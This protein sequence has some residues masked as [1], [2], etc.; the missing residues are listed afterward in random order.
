[1]NRSTQA[2]NH[3][4][5]LGLRKLAHQER[6]IELLFEGHRYWDLKRWKT[7]THVLNEPIQGWDI[8][9]EDA[10]TYYRVRLLFNQQFRMRDY[11]WPIKESELLVNR[12]LV[13]SPG[14]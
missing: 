13:Q 1:M 7:A 3:T 4:T 11:F 9:Q 8:Y 5:Q 12:N 14:W 10:A 2:T 6:M